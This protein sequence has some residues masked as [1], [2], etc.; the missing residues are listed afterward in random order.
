MLGVEF[1]I[2]TVSVFVGML[3]QAVK[4]I[5]TNY[6]KKDVNKFIPIFSVIFGILLGIA[7]YYMPEV[8]FG[9]SLIT[10]IFTGAA[11]GASATGVHQIAKQLETEPLVDAP[12]NPFPIDGVNEDFS[13]NFEPEEE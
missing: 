9:S 6:F 7:G 13:R 5:A 10:A 3:N 4:F 11:A 2:P 12:D 1:G 8:E